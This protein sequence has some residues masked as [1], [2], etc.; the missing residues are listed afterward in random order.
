MNRATQRQ[1][2]QTTSSRVTTRKRGVDTQTMLKMTV[3]ISQ[4]CNDKHEVQPNAS[5]I[6]ALAELLGSVIAGNSYC[7]QANTQVSVTGCARYVRWTSSGE[8]L[9]CGVFR[10]AAPACGPG[11]PLVGADGASYTL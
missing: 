2:W 7:S 8:M 9:R 6:Q 10:C 1:S 5:P 4:A 11:D 3:Y